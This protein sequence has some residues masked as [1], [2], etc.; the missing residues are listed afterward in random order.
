M[1]ERQFLDVEE[2][3]ASDHAIDSS[4]GSAAQA[5]S[6]WATI[7]ALSALLLTAALVLVLGGEPRAVP[8]GQLRHSSTTSAYKH[9]THVAFAPA[10]LAAPQRIPQSAGYSRHHLPGF[11]IGPAGRMPLSA[12]N[13][14]NINLEVPMPQTSRSHLALSETGRINNPALQ[15]YRP[16]TSRSGHISGILDDHDDKGVSAAEETELHTVKKSDEIKEAETYA[17]NLMKA[18]DNAGSKA[19]TGKVLSRQHVVAS[20]SFA[21]GAAVIFSNV[22]LAMAGLPPGALSQQVNTVATA[23]LEANVDLAAILTTVREKALGT[24][25]ASVISAFAQVF[26]MMWLHTSLN[27]QYR[28][29]GNLT[30]TLSKLYKEGGIGRLY[31]GLPIAMVQAP[32]VRFGM[33][34]AN[35]GMLALLDSFAV[36]AMLPL[37]IKVAAGAITG[38]LWKIFCMPIDTAKM[39]MNVEGK[40]GF[41]KL[42]DK[43]LRVGPGPLY[44]GYR[45]ALAASFSGLFPWWLTHSFLDGRLPLV[46]PDRMLLSLVRA[47]CIGFAA[48]CVSETVSNSFTVI[49]T[50]QQ[51]GGL[52]SNDTESDGIS[53]D[54]KGM[55]IA[56]AL[57]LVLE[58]DG[59]KGLF[60]RGLK[61]K[62]L[63]NGISGTLFNVLWKFFQIQGEVAAR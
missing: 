32:L 14:N 59:V 8:V 21:I 52:N 54:A 45:A 47:G 60:G 35:V 41:R 27:Y 29:G 25:K 55:P 38:G 44:Q 9:S 53:K 20:L 43:V 46:S 49:K 42:R 1:A 11:L 6:R 12:A 33:I 22:E 39:A 36:S 34:A 16:Q 26:S 5:R 62:I 56:E 17:W 7:G 63:M 40:A 3:E 13:R 23:A 2:A 31:R 58:A 19:V 24:G 48:A 10:H 57:R 28:Y 4:G 30:S 18:A 51:L 61:T 15:V 50:N 37:P